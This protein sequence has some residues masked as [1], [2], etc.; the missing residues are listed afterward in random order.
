MRSH[1]RREDMLTLDSAGAQ[2]RRGSGW[3]SFIFSRPHVCPLDGVWLCAI[4][5]RP[6]P[7][8]LMF[9]MSWEVESRLF[10]SGC[11]G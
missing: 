3:H 2:S 7:A 6:G 11:R 8:G 10:L 5:S 9:L 4:A 1:P